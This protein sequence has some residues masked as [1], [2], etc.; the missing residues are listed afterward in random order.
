MTTPPV[1]A[2]PRAAFWLGA[3][4][5]LPLTLSNVP[6]AFVTGVAGTQAGMSPLEVTLMSAWVFAGA[7]QLVSLQLMGTGAAIP[8]VLLAGL[9]VNLRYIMYSS[10]VAKPLAAF[11]GWLKALAAFLLVDQNFVLAVQRFEAYGPHL[12][13]WFYMG[14]GT[15]LWV[16]WVVSTFIGAYLGARVPAAWSLEFAVPLCFLVL[17]V[18]VLKTRPSIAAALVGGLVATAFAWLPYRSGLFLGAIAGIAAGVW[19]ENRML[20]RRA[21]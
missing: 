9:V 15:P 17:L 12:T 19:L 13:P 2:T 11:R 16:N 1:P 18:P 14:V 6:F 5:V 3:V 8:F 21:A 10:A 20:G 4:T 7:A